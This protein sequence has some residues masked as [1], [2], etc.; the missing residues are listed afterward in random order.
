MMR[1]K[2]LIRMSFLLLAIFT[3]TGCF[4]P[5]SITVTF[6]TGGGTPIEAI[7]TD[8]KTPV[9]FPDD[10]VL[11][12]HMFEGWSLSSDGSGDLLSDQ[13]DFENDVTLYAR[14]IILD[15]TLSFETNGGSIL[16]DMRIPY[17]SIVTEPSTPTKDGHA[18]AGWYDD[19]GFITPHTFDTMPAHDIT[20]YA[21]WLIPVTFDS[22]GGTTVTN[23]NVESG[24]GL[25][26]PVASKEGYTLDGWYIS[27][28]NGATYDE[29]WSFATMDVH[30]A[31]T[32]HAKWVPNTYTVSF[33]GNTIGGQTPSDMRV[34]Y[35]TPYGALP[36][37]EEKTGHI[38]VGWALPSGEIVSRDTPLQIPNDH[39]LQAV[40]EA[41]IF[42]VTFLY[43]S[44]TIHAT[45]M[46][47]FG[48]LIVLPEPPEKTGYTFNYWY[49][50]LL[51]RDLSDETR[52]ELP[53][54][55]EA[56][57][58]WITNK[59]SI[60]FE[61]NGGQPIDELIFFYDANL[62]L[63]VPVKSGQ[64]FMG[65]FTDASL[66][67]PLSYGKMPDFDF[68]VYALWHTMVSFDNHGGPALTPLTGHSGETITEPDHP[69]L[70]GH[71]FLGWFTDATC[72]V[73]YDFTVFPE[74]NTTVHVGW[75]VNRYT[76]TFDSQDG[77]P[78]PEQTLDYGT[79]LSG[80]VPALDGFRFHGW[81]LD[82]SCAGTR[83]LTVPDEDVTLYACW[84]PEI[85][86]T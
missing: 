32:L 66:E 29:R 43:D 23:Q 8:E 60:S 31:M 28:N 39:T 58:I 49:S 67:T 9:T 64:T 70:E 27:L 36:E 40:Y 47:P 20:L 14:W 35:D 7:V 10:P 21:K 25:T 6:D 38:F 72:T 11:T 79:D 85:V 59:Y 24:Q 3:L 17:G 62:A 51:G 73:P 56:R 2:R 26:V 16:D 68:T 81:Y 45:V 46:V 42:T 33:D 80:F 78:I 54:D 86:G 84:V 61:T 41:Y 4:G 12:G 74:M 83:I 63:P 44:E 50:D 30:H 53:Y 48:D 13:T 69:V 65:W 19:P 57:P 22:A 82:P 15:F 37:P 52:L 77:S 1:S 75:E 18:F 5:D 71:T 55:L 34:T 76:V